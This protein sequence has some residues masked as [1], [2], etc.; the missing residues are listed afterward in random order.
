MV[1][2]RNMKSITVLPLEWNVNIRHSHLAPEV[3][4]ALV[5]GIRMSSLNYIDPAAMRNVSDLDLYKY[6]DVYITG[7]INNVTVSD[8]VQT[9]DE[10][11]YNDRNRD[12]RRHGGREHGDRDRGGGQGGGHGG[13]QGGGGH[14]GRGHDDRGRG[15]GH[16]NRGRGRN[17]DTNVVRTVTRT[18]TVDIEYTYFRASNNEVLGHFKKRA[19][20]YD[21]SDD[22]RFENS[23]YLRSSGRTPQSYQPDSWTDNIAAAAIKQ[24]SGSMSR[25]LGLWTTSEKRTLKGSAGSRALGEADKL[26]RQ[27]YYGRA[28]EIYSDTY[29]RTGDISAGYNLAVLQ[30]FDGKF[31]EAL[32]LLEEIRQAVIT[33]GK[34]VPDY[35][36]NEIVK[37][38]GF[39][40]GYIVLDGYKETSKN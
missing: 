16:D 21:S 24:F 35:I 14:D 9:R 22:I 28:Y 26:I 10:P 7:R 1:D 29:K 31:S 25:E 6:V 20:D 18:V 17:D 15:R 13:G 38:K 37:I 40:D 32:E 36:S 4:A 23:S 34:K 11:I 2:L 33:S 19:A 8:H 30:Q 27:R 5:Y 39:I 12:G 3:S